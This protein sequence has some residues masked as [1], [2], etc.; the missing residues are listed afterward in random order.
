HAVLSEID[1]VAAAAGVVLDHCEAVTSVGA[2]RRAPLILLGLDQ[3]AAAV[4][5]KMPRRDGVVVLAGRDPDA[6]QWA[7]CLRLGAHRGLG[8]AAAA[9]DLVRRRAAS[10]GAA[11]DG[12]G[13][14]DGTVT[15]TV[16]ACGG[17]GATVL[18]V[19]T[20][21]AA[22]RSGRPSVLEEADPWGAGV[23]V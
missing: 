11:G 19:A 10:A 22:A 9:E 7:P 14:G 12:D 15:A 8:R 21:C 1:R 5:S 3:V 6:D 17:A 20:A 4:S 23:D 13:S 18:A 16:G 2:W